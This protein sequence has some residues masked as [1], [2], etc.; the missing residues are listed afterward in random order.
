MKKTLFVLL[1]TGLVLFLGTCNTNTNP[2]ETPDDGEGSGEPST[3]DD[4]FLISDFSGSD[5]VGGTID[6]TDLKLK[7]ISNYA[8]VTVN[9]TLYTDRTGTNKAETPAGDNKNLAQFSLLKA[10]TSGWDD[11]NRCGPAKDSMAVEGDT[12]WNVPPAASGTPAYLLVQ[13]NQTDFSTGTMVQSIKIFKITF[14]PRTSDPSVILDKVYGD[15]YTVSGNKITFNNA[16]GSDGAALLIFPDSFP[17]GGA[18]NLPLSSQYQPIPKTLPQQAPLT[19]NI[20]FV[21]KRLKT[22]REKI[23]L[24]PVVIISYT[25]PWTVLGK[26]AGLQTAGAVLLNWT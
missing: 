19:R 4:G 9:A 7:D 22:L 1:I 8:S 26:Q 2:G 21:F 16:S 17:K 15:K 12:V 20:R 24:T 3:W 18:K 11:A 13:A 14:T 10:G 6:L 25:L 5:Y 23:K